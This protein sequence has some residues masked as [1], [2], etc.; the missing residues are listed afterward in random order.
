MSESAIESTGPSSKVSATMRSRGCASATRVPNS[1]KV[2]ECAR[3]RTL[4]STS[5]RLTSDM[6]SA[7]RRVV[8]FAVPRA[9]IRGSRRSACY[10][11]TAAAAARG[12]LVRP[13]YASQSMMA[14]MTTW[15]KLRPMFSP[16]GFCCRKPVTR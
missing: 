14:L 9:R 1:W 13:R 11:G 6:T 10:A 5:S 16:S 3:F 15:G 4:A 12:T 2:R 8:G 7:T